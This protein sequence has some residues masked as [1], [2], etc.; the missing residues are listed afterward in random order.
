MFPVSR[1]GR[2][3]VTLMRGLPLL[4][5]CEGVLGEIHAIRSSRGRYHPLAMQNLAAAQS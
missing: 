3:G 2:A 5:A 1:F 4:G